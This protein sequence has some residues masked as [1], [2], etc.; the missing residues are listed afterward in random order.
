MKLR[1]GESTMGLFQ[2]AKQTI[3]LDVGSGFIK[4][5]A[6]DHG[7]DEPRLVRLA[8]LPLASDAIVEG[9][10]MDP[11][12]VVDAIQ[13]V[14]Q[15]LGVKARGVATAVGGRDV[16]VKKIRMDRLSEAD[17]REV[18]HWEAEQYVPFDMES[19]QLDF[20]VLDP[21]QEGPQMSV[22][23]VAAKRDLV[24]QRLM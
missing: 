5:V 6:V 13:E 8:S 2:R 19:V 9:E 23:L 18:L 20:Q 11:R 22:L 12:A 3:G 14:V 4:A 1:P 21:Q 17:A 24:E 16:I 7:G 15:A 10:I